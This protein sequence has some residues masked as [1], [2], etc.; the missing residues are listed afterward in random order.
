MCPTQANYLS[1]EIQSISFQPTGRICSCGGEMK[2]TLL[3]CTRSRVFPDQLT[4]SGDD[5]L[6][7][8]AYERAQDNCEKADLVICLGTSLRVA[9]A[10]TLPVTAVRKNHAKLVIVNLQVRLGSYF[11]C[12][13]FLLHA[14]DTQGPVCS[15]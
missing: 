10:N 15:H 13:M 3:D 7:E 14:A 2:D 5:P 8:E 6:P 9:P 12:R 11:A 4:H 1:E